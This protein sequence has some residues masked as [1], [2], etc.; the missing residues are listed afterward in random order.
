MRVPCSREMSA[1]GCACAVGLLALTPC[2]YFQ[3]THFQLQWAPRLGARYALPAPCARCQLSHR[4][5]EPA[6]VCRH[7]CSGMFAAWSARSARAPFGVQCVE[8]RSGAGCCVPSGLCERVSQPTRARCNKPARGPTQLAAPLLSCD[9]LPAPSLRPR[10]RT[11][12]CGKPAS[13]QSTLP[14]EAE[15]ACRA[16]G[17]EGT[18]A[19]FWFSRMRVS[20]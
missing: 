1:A 3:S 14:L 12:T 18:R 10:L 20:C 15:T 19:A 5:A 7:A 6:G 8:R 11:R 17:A 4:S 13:R 9:T 16:H 2:E